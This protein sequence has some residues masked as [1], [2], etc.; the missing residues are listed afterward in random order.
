M[1][2]QKKL[3]VYFSL[4]ASSLIISS[5]GTSSTIQSAQKFGELASRFEEN[6]NNLADDIYNSCIRKIQF[7]QVDTSESNEARDVALKDCNDLNKPTARQARDAN[8]LVTD[9]IR[10][11]AKLASDDVVSFDNELDKVKESLDNLSI[12]ISSGN[13]LSLPSNAV[14]GG[15]SIAKFLFRWATA[16]FREGV[17]KEAVVCTDKPFQVY[18]EGLKFVFDEAYINGILDQELFRVQSYYNYYAALLRQNPDGP[19]RD[20]AFRQLQTESFNAIQP[21]LERQDAALAYI[22]IIG[23][24]SNTHSELAKLFSDGEDSPDLSSCS[25]YFGDD[26]SISVSTQFVGQKTLNSELTIDELI[27]VKKIILDYQEEI[28]PLLIQMEESL[29]R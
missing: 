5:C 3:K 18:T 10:A 16:D 29:E 14:D 17:L 20:R 7:F 12:P 6:T 19:A 9:Y 28:E 13:T 15:I 22:S 21:V 11:I 4:L 26:S 25:T 8:K 23:K 2:F 24:T 1:R 27:T